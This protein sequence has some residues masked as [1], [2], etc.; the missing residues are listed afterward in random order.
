MQCLY[1]LCM[2]TETKMKISVSSIFFSFQIKTNSFHSWM[3]FRIISHRLN[4]NQESKWGDLLKSKLLNYPYIAT[5]SI[6]FLKGGGN[7]IKRGESFNLYL[8]TSSSVITTSLPHSMSKLFCEFTL[9]STVAPIWIRHLIVSTRLLFFSKSSWTSGE[10]GC[11]FLWSSCT[12]ALWAKTAQ[13]R[14]VRPRKKYKKAEIKPPINSFSCSIIT[15]LGGSIYVTYVWAP[16]EPLR[17]PEDF[18]HWVL[19]LTLSTEYFSFN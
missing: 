4:T 13:C 19:A 2:T 6:N 14:G 5:H 3:I 1:Y 11:W 10:W 15:D 9:A 18:L 7:K 17:K 8:G 12:T 16:Q